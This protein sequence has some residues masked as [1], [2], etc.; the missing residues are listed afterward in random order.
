MTLGAA[1]AGAEGAL[2]RAPKALRPRRRTGGLFWFAAPGVALVLFFFGLPFV[3]NIFLSFM[4]WTGFSSK[5]GFNGLDNFISLS[6]LGILG[7]ATWVTVA[8]AV[9]TMVGQN[10]IALALSKALQESNRINTVFRSI[11][12]IPVLISPLAAGYIWAAA[13]AP[14]GPVNAFIGV[15]VPGFEYAWLGESATALIAVGLIDAWKWSGL[16]TLVYIAGLNSINRSVIEA[17]VLDGA[18][19]WQRFRRIEMPLLAPS[20]TFNIILTL[21][22]SFNALDIVFATTKG[23]PGDATTV[24]NA[25]V[26]SQYGQGLFG[27]SSALSFMIALLVIVVAVPLL[28]VLRKREVHG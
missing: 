6:K 15:F 23:G 9:I 2:K 22:G 28:M 16:V 4:K 26:Y 19:A 5:I 13:L 25:A 11:Y 20:F 7:H 3:A 8:Y 14:K 17:A 21:V 24:L 1:A 27:T 12:F 18:N 10:V